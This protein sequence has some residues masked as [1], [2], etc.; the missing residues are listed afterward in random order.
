VNQAP[1]SDMLRQAVAAHEAG[2]LAEARAGYDLVLAREPEHGWAHYFRAVLAEAEGDATLALDHLRRAAR[3]CDPPAQALVALG[4]RELANRQARAALTTFEAATRLRPR[5]AAAFTGCA[6]ALKRLGRLADAME[7]GRRALELRRGWQPGA[8]SPP[9]HL[10]PA[11]VTEMR[12]ANRVKLAHDAAQLGYLV[13][14]G[15]AIPEAE[16]I[17][18]GYERLLGELRVLPHDTTVVTLDDRALATTLHAYNRLLHLPSTSV[19]VEGP[20]SAGAGF[21]AADRQFEK[22]RPL[23]VIIDNVL[24]PAALTDLQRFIREATIWFEVKDHGGHLGAYFE[25]GLACDLLIAIAETFRQVLPRSL[26]GLGLA[27]LWAYKHVQGGSGTDLHADMGTVS[28]NL[29]ITPDDASL[30]PEA[31]GMEIW[32]VRMPEGWDFKQANVE[33]DGIRALL[34]GKGDPIVV[35]HRCNRLVLFEANLFHRT[36]PGGFKPGYESRRV[37]I[38][39]LYDR[40]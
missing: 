10:D 9:G 29:W 14:H 22:C 28:A 1:T 12:R 15:A 2:R 16:R 32:P 26:E 34:A 23:P 13:A 20:L 35:P 3:G 6:L 37:N 38:T 8:S 7:A 39:F 25:E 36:S 30:D 18:S 40:L 27:Q 24:S 17:T 4:N 11:E 19:A 33:R 31:G 21:A 5:F